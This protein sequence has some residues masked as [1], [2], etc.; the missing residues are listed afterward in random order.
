MDRSIS[1][2]G[3]HIQ[4]L[5]PNAELPDVA[6]VRFV[7]LAES[8]QVLADC[9]TEAGFPASA[10]ADG[11]LSFGAIPDEQAEAQ[12]VAVYT[13]RAMYPTDP[14]Y[15]QPFTEE[16][17]AYLYHYSAHELT[18]CVQASGYDVPEL[19]SRSVFDQGMSGETE[20]WWNP[21]KL[22]A[23]EATHDELMAVTSDCPQYPHEL[24]G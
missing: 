18:E 14:S 9:I 24:W 10:T 3:D 5:F 2:Y 16:Q 15:L 17:L 23:E 12:S 19:P 8:P 21:Y 22:V 20:Y 6:T 4:H 11:G 1:E 7:A 13:C